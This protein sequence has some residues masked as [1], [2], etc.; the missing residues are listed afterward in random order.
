M[1]R[2]RSIRPGVCVLEDR[3]VLNHGS[4]AAV[5][6]AH[7][8]NS[9]HRVAT[10]SFSPAVV[11]V[12][13]LGDSYT[14]EY[15]FYPPDRS[16]ARGWVEILSATRGIYFGP[17]TDQSRGSPRYA[18]YA[19]D[20]ALTDSTSSEMVR[21]QLPG[22]AAQ[23]ARGRIQYA[24]I[25]SGA[26]DYLNLLYAVQAGTVSPTDA[27]NA[28]PQL[29][30][31]ASAN[32]DTAIT[33]LLAASPKLKLV[34]STLPAVG[35]L[36]IVKQGETTPEAQALVAATDQAIVGLNDAIKASVA[37][38][39]P[40]ATLVDLAAASE[41]LASSPG[42]VPF[43]GI[44]LDLV[45]PGDSYDHFYLADGVHVGTVGQGLIA[46][47]FINAVDSAFGA[48]IAPL[49]PTQIVHYAQLVWYR[50]HHAGK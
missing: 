34:V 50:V 40:R 25:F 24:W 33:T 6:H 18:G 14:D 27:A 41:Q 2:N 30:A 48:H 9:P 8:H 31:Q 39:G 28:L 36:P 4:A 16:Q 13:A 35:F 45:T 49:T 32:I 23:V 38:A 43:G 29:T 11:S 19:Y 26:D 46:D 21:S 10:P 7:A 15:I 42:S 1:S 17:H 12:G 3:L 22:L 20:W 37:A 5:T 47:Q 44:T